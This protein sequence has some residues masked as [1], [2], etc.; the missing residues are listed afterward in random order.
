MDDASPRW[1]GKRH[2]NTTPSEDAMSAQRV[3]HPDVSHIAVLYCRV[4]TSAQEDNGTSLDT[5]EE[6]CRK[7]CIEQGLTVLSSHRDTQSGATLDR[8]GLQ[9]AL[10]AI[11]NHHA[12]VP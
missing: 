6:D 7:H 10:A 11:R 12:A 1:S 2:L 4:S 5:Q 3:T 9:T 8:P